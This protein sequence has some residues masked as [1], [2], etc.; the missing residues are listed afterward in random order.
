MTET[1]LRNT[2]ANDFSI[3]ASLVLHARNTYHKLEVHSNN[4]EMVEG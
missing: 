1:Q 2:G 3:Q 4:F